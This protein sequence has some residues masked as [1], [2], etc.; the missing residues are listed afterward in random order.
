MSIPWLSEKK[1]KRKRKTDYKHKHHFHQHAATAKSLNKISPSHLLPLP[2]PPPCPLLLHMLFCT[3]PSVPTPCSLPSNNI[4]SSNQNS[5]RNVRLAGY[6]SN[7]RFSKYSVLSTQE[8]WISQDQNFD[9]QKPP[10][11]PKKLIW[12]SQTYKS[13]NCNVHI[14]YIK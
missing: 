6:Y 4:A 7:C 3:H 13:I 12:L 14:M 10:E 9:I 1:K 5:G 8:R 11:N 2:S